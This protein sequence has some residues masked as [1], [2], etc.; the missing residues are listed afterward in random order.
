MIDPKNFN[1][2]GKTVPENEII[3]PSVKVVEKEFIHD[4]EEG[5]KTFENYL[6]KE[7][8]EDV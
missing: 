6:T 3:I 5:L 7:Y 1:T 4:I 2:H 8:G